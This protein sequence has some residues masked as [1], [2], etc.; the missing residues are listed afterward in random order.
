MTIVTNF[1]AHNASNLSV[2][3]KDK[4]DALFPTWP[5]MLATILSLIILLTILTKMVYKPVKK[6]F[7]NRQ[8]YIQNNIKE[9]E[10]MNS[11]AI[12]DRELADNELMRAQ[13]EATEIISNAKVKAEI[14]RAEKLEIAKE[15]VVKL[16]KDAKIDIKHQ[17]EKFDEESKEAIINVALTAASKVI[18]KEVDNKTNRKIISDF[19]KAK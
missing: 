11:Q 5:T 13:I 14:V 17:Q 18:E 12:T 2:E 15:E 3:L 4:F 6:S 1:V 10:M 16:V 19:I 7:Q 8:N 9:A